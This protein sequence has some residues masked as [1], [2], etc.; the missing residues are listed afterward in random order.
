[1]T[2]AGG[3]NDIAQ[4]IV[5]Q[6]NLDSYLTALAGAMTSNMDKCT[7]AQLKQEI[8]Y[9]L[10]YHRYNDFFSLS[11]S[12]N[13]SCSVSYVKYSVDTNGHITSSTVTANNNIYKEFNDLYVPWRD[14]KIY[15]QYF[16][17]M[18]IK[19]LTY[20]TMKEYKGKYL[21]DFTEVYSCIVIGVA[22]A[23][24][25]DDIETD[26]AIGTI[27]AFVENEGNTFI[28]HQ[29][30]NDSG[31][32]SHLTAGLKEL[33]GQNYNKLTTDKTQVAETSTY[34]ADSDSNKT[35]HYYSPLLKDTRTAAQK[36]EGS[37]Q[38]KAPD[39]ISLTQTH[40]TMVNRG[41]WGNNEKETRFMYTQ[42]AML[43]TDTQVPNTHK[44]FDA[45]LFY[46]KSFT[47]RATQTNKGLVTMY[48]F[49]IS[50]QL[51]IGQTHPNTFSTD[52]A[53]KDLVVYYT[54][55]GGQN[56]NQSSLVAADP[57]DGI[58][59]YWLYSYGSV[60]YCGA[61]HSSITGIHVDNNDE[62]RLFINI[63]LN[64]VKKS[65][66]GPTISV[67]DPYPV[68]NAVGESEYI[69]KDI[70]MTEDGIYEMTIPNLLTVPEFTYRVTVP[71]SKDEVDEVKI[72]YDLSN[73]TSGGDG[74]GFVNG[75]DVMI[76]NA[77]ST[78]DPSILKDLYKLIGRA[79][80]TLTLDQS[81][82]SPYDNKYTYIVIAVKTR[83]GIYTTQRIMVKLAPKLWDLT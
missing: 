19:Y 70:T 14:A 11:N 8:A 32:T 38:Y 51:K 9:E 6:K 35:I 18:Y 5:A 37:S 48:P 72:Y 13:D 79:L 50:S 27:Q 46:T 1:M 81:Y 77:N 17:K 66:F 25:E 15:E 65:V 10:K 44:D 47:N 4:Y 64:S 52:I 53:D 39:S 22:E 60:T 2:A 16:Y 67:Y 41:V 45:E 42:S 78:N 63:I 30:I 34:A 31:S 26:D 82:F 56:G 29:T 43:Y 58:D 12:H 69:N 62:R 55:A 71:D 54:L 3:T 74:F 21:P 80:S 83:K 23:F 24:G 20:A 61:G 7:N 59:N 33:F 75:T 57:Q 68:T 49:L 36:V 76:F 73:N 28:F 40:R